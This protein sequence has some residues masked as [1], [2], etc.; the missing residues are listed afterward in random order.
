[1]RR[2]ISLS[3]CCG[4]TALFY[5]PALLK[6]VEMGRALSLLSLAGDQVLGMTQPPVWFYS[7]R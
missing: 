1:M 3:T 6:P 7:L 4:N 5:T 2:N